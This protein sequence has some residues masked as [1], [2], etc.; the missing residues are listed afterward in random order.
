MDLEIDKIKEKINNMMDDED[1]NFKKIYI[2]K[3]LEE[4]NEILDTNNFKELKN[5]EI[6]ENIKLKNKLNKYFPYLL[7]S[8]FFETIE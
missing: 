4:I 8:L 5:N 3:K 2:F 7:L 6:K 1:N